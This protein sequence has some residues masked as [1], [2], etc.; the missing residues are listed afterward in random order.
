MNVIHTSCLHKPVH[1]H[2]ISYSFSSVLHEWL[3]M[4]H[5]SFTARQNSSF[6]VAF[7]SACLMGPGA[8]QGLLPIN[9]TGRTHSTF[10]WVLALQ[11]QKQ[12]AK[13]KAR[14]RQGSPSP[15]SSRAGPLE[16]WGASRSY[17]DLL[18]HFSPAGLMSS[19]HLA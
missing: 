16:P 13:Y 19:V 2:G 15:P 11:P 18:K 10:H 17:G 7:L 14:S 9:N 5:K 1:L 8:E 4:G 6:P 3:K 12:Q